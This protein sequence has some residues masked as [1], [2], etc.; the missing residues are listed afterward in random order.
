MECTYLKPT[1][2]I[3]VYFFLTA[4]MGGGELTDFGVGV[5]GIVQLAVHKPCFV[6]WLGGNYFQ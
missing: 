6:R 1:L 4:E 5:V 3:I 2:N